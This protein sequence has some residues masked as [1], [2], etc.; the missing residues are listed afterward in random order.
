[1]SARKRLPRK[2]IANEFGYWIYSVDHGKTWKF[3]DNDEPLVKGAPFPRVCKKCHHHR[4]PDR[5]DPCIANLPGVEFACCGHGDSEGYIK[6]LAALCSE[7][8]L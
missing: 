8:S 5:H 3:R 6:F 4:T 1:M 2:L 7:A